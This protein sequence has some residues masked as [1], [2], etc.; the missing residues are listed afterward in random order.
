VG[1]EE[2]SIMHG[3]ST[4]VHGAAAS[5]VTRYACILCLFY[6]ILKTFMHVGRVGVVGG[7]VSC[8]NT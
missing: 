4:F 8:R 3:R 1:G 2:R 7:G 6:F 5:H